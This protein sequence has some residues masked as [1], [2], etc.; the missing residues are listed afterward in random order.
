MAA[1]V[2]KVK[3]VFGTLTHPYLILPY[4]ACYDHV[5][6]Q[7]LAIPCWRNMEKLLVPESPKEKTRFTGSYCAHF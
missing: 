6:S 4:S 5:A 3:G 2:A 1:M 7:Y